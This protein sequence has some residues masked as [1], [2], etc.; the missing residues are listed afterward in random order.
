[1]IYG[2]SNAQG[3]FAE[4]KVKKIEKSESLLAITV[5]VGMKRK[6]QPFF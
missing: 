2:L 6:L 3:F 5:A 1:M 4:K